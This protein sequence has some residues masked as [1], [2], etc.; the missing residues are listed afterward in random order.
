M[1]EKIGCKYENTEKEIKGKL[2]YRTEEG[3]F[4]AVLLGYNLFST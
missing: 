4:L 1:G 3:D 2:G